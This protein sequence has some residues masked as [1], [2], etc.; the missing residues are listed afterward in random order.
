MNHIMSDHAIQ[1]S[2]SRSIGD[3]DISTALLY[4]E[5]IEQ[6]GLTA[7]FVGEKL[8]LQLADKGIHCTKN[9]AV[10]VATDGAIISVIRTSD[11]HRLVKTK[12]RLKRR[13]TP[14]KRYVRALSR[15]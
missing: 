5:E 4:G 14:S 9:I 6:E 7:Y 13:E 15:I 10:L 11:R 12:N 8:A 3:E 1:R 2:A